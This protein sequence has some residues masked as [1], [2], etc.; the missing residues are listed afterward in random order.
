MGLFHYEAPPPSSTGTLEEQWRAWIKQESLRRLGWAVYVRVSIPFAVSGVKLRRTQEYDSS[1]SY[2][3]N[4]RPN[5]G[6]AEMNMDL[7]SSAE[8]WEAESAE[9]WAAL[10]PWTDR[11]PKTVSFR[12]LIRTLFD[13]T[14]AAVSKIVDD[15]HGFIIILTLMRMLWSM[16]EVEGSP[17][18]DLIRD[19]DR[20]AESRKHLLEVL[21]RFLPLGAALSSAYTRKARTNIV[22]KAQIVH[23]AHLYGAGDL[24]DWLYP[25]VRGGK[26]AE[27]VK[28]RMVRWASQDIAR[29]RRVTYHSAQA[30]ALIRQYP[31]NMPLEAFNAFHAGV[32]LWCMTDLLPQDSY[33]IQ[34]DRLRLDQL[35]S[36]ED[37]ASDPVRTWIRDGGQYV[38]WLYGVPAFGCEGSRH[39]ILEQTAE[40]LERMRVWGISQN[41]LKVILGLLEIESPSPTEPP[42][43]SAS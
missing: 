20:L 2:L 31:Y 17:I 27:N 39:Q 23:M 32:V 26:A 9:A 24:M 37:P 16:K 5:I 14:E 19:T 13:G 29:V 8:H 6:L 7:P 41:F 15:R 11:C 1:V 34:G 36:P 30:L 4:T 43:V 28:T 22:H 40:I 12:S 35:A 42:T 10:Q 25:L 21:D 33:G 3:H 38:L 18:S